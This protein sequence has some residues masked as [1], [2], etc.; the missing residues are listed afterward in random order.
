MRFCKNSEDARAVV[1]AVHIRMLQHSTDD[2][3]MEHVALRYKAGY[4][5]R[6]TTA[7][8]EELA[9]MLKKMSISSC[10]IYTTVVLPLKCRYQNRRLHD[11]Q[12]M[13]GSRQPVATG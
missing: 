1:A 10:V 8:L 9:A 6:C 3:K 5:S 12:H 11:H 13:R 4:E 7:L 2:T